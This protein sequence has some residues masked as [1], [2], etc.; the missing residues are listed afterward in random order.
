MGFGS[1]GGG[2]TP[3][4]NNVPG[5]TKTGTDK[6]TDVHEFT[7]SVDIT[8]SLT[9]NGSAVTGGGGGGGAVSSYTNS[10]DNRVITSVN[11]STINGEANFTFDGTDLSV[12]ADADITSS[13]GK[14]AIGGAGLADA[15]T[16]SH[17]DHN[18]ATN[19]ALR[20][21]GST[22]Q[23]D[24]NAA[25]GQPISFQQNGSTKV[26]I[27]SSGRLGIG[28]N[29][30][31]AVLHVS[32]GV[33]TTDPL[34]RID[35]ANQGPEQ[36]LKPILFVTGSGLVGIGTDA[37]RTDASSSGNPETNRL[38]I[39]GEYGADQGVDPVVNS[40]LMLENDNHV[41][42]QFM[43]P[44]G[45]AGQLTW[46]TPA[47]ARK[48]TYYYDSN[49]NRFNWEGLTYGTSK[50]MDLAVGG[51][52]LNIGSKNAAHMIGAGTAQANLHISSSTHGV[53][54]GGP[55]MLKID[56]SSSANI[57]YVTG[58]GLVGIG[59]DEPEHHLHI[60]SAGKA[61]LL[62]EA[63]TDN[64]PESDT[65]YIKLTQDNEATRMIVGLNGNAGADPD[66]VYLAN[67]MSNAG[68]VGPRTAGSI[69]DDG[70]VGIGDGFTQGTSPTAI[71]HI[72]GGI[73]AQGTAKASPLM[74]VEYDDNDNILFVTGSGL[75]GIGTNV[76]VQTLSVSGSAAFSGA[77]GSSAVENFVTSTGVVNSSMGNTIID[78]TG[79]GN[80]A[81]Y[82]YGIA[83]GS[84]AG[85]QKNLVFK[86]NFG[87]AIANTNGLQV[88]GSNI[89]T[90]MPGT[91]DG[92]VIMSASD[93]GGGYFQSL[94]GSAQL[95]WDGS[96]WQ[97]LAVTN[98]QYSGA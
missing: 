93:G 88:T 58:S 53:D 89:D 94:R 41:G 97:V 51:D 67:A 82:S 78:I 38:H 96:K 55:V 26:V 57:L 91:S 15:A 69:I 5:S 34:F 61:S 68:I 59:T 45:R 98:A 9:L 13:L 85:Q 11:S 71:L 47:A 44:T 28:N 63:D 54:K 32:G 3:S 1:G 80:N 83:N 19:Y 7:G 23:T 60:K 79:L 64:T 37:P 36:T 31:T 75:V 52:C 66:G 84:F 70:Q 62:L 14:A 20:Q 24:I 2:F 25:N 92:V 72:S 48:A 42:I 76:P 77:F 4:P 27:D 6:D 95:L 39:M 12:S 33:S 65:A 49:Y 16:F 30:P 17:V 40:V 29:T 21:R 87:G 35:S 81:F 18:S 56:H 43:F 8:G 90:A 22:G 73:G 50:V 74:L 10:G 46:G 86:A